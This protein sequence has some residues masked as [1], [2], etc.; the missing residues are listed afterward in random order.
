MR[1]RSALNIHRHL[2]R[3]EPLRR[4]PPQGDADRFAVRTMRAAA[5]NAA[6]TVNAVAG[7]ASV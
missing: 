6:A 7:D 2:N 4:L 3:R 5:I 1:P